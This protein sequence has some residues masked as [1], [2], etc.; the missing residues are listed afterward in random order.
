M[1][2]QIIIFLSLFFLS[3]HGL[4]AKV[5]VPTVFSD[6]MVLQQQTE[7]ALWGKS[8]RCSR[9]V[10]TASWSKHRTIIHADTS[11]RW[12]CHIDTPAAG[13]PYELVFDDGEKTIIKNVMIGE[14]WICSGQSNMEM[15]MKGFAGQPVDGAVEMILS[16]K[17]SIPI[18]SC[19]FKKAKAFTPQE[20]CEAKWAEHD[21]VGVADAS[22]VAY[23]FARRLYDV[24]DVPIG[25]INISWGGTPIEA[26]MSREVLESEFAD[27]VDL[28]CVVNKVW[29]ER[30]SHQQPAVL[31]NG[32]LHSVIPYTAKGFIWYQGCFNRRNYNQY[33]RL[34][35]VFVKMLRDKW[36]N[37]EMPFY[38]T[39]IAPYGYND[40]EPYAGYM[41]WAQAQTL[42]HIKYS[43]MA[44]T[45]DVGELNC[46][47]PSNKKVVGDRLAY[48]ALENDYSLKVID[49]H[50][51]LPVKF[52]FRDSAALVSF[53]F[54][55]MGLTPIGTELGGFELA[56]EDKVFYPAKCHVSDRNKKQIVVCSPQV[57]KPV[58]VRYGMKN[59][60]RAVLFNCYGIPVSPFRS[61]DWD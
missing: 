32:M 12:S 60:S 52:E 18:R 44:A 43:G 29:P 19:N 5:T 3:V 25:I 39:Q 53:D 8:S 40:K 45:H 13:G 9:V 47:H 50:T 4:V 1:V 17:P 36:E 58:A 54:C 26:W 21:P 51:P 28:S 34:Q 15:P 24:L 10:I 33:R 2:K 14:V 23:F 41:M 46:I 49:S 59:F 35:P 55:E 37:E 57:K 31:Y 27:E 38:F 16:A 48:L 11:G 7:V 30:R 42:D 61:D 56:G 20:N 22:A 6:N